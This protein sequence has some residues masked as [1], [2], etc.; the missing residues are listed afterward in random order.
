MGLSPPPA[1][2]RRLPEIAPA[3]FYKKASVPVEGTVPAADATLGTQSGSSAPARE[4]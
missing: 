1:K 2:R 3:N 4:R